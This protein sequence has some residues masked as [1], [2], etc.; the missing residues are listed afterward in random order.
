M[1]AQEKLGV[2]EQEGDIEARE[3]ETLCAFVT[4]DH[5]DSALRCIE[6]YANSDTWWGMLVQP[7]PL[8]FRGKHVLTVSQAPEPSSI[9]WENLAETQMSRFLR[10]SCTSVVS[11]L[12]IIFSIAL[13]YYAQQTKSRFAEQIPDLSVCK[14]SLPNHFGVSF[15]WII[16]LP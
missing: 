3:R 10:R 14:G 5:E 6:D 7:K 15:L 9:M 13:I 1:K 12:L 4:F 8:R 2:M 16:F 11:M